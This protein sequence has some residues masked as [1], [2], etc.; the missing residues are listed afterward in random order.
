VKHR[1]RKGLLYLG[2]GF[3]VLFCLRLA[4]GYVYPSGGSGL[5]VE[6]MTNALVTTLGG[7]DEGLSKANYA[8]EKFKVERGDSGQAYTVSQKY[9]KIASVISRTS[10]FEE[11]EERVRDL[12]ARHSALIQFERAAGLPGA[13]RVD[14]AIGVPPARFDPM[15]GELKQIGE[16]SSLRVDKTDKTNEYRELKAKRATLEK[17]RDA[18]V[19]LKSK[20]GRIEEFTSLEN[21]ILEIEDEIQS[22]GVSLG[23]YD[24]ENEFC[25]VR[26]SLLEKG[27]ATATISFLHRVRVALAWTIK[28]YAL[29]VGI[30]FF[31]A[32]FSLV[33][34]VLLQRL[35][36][37]PPAAPEPAASA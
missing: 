23:D 14:L 21:R 35:R 27:A 15:V 8:S 24:E 10:A 34:V 20:G 13:R 33:V 19:A 37:I 28:Y 16:L 12:T 6:S 17:T 30:L 22:A 1:I 26:L 36:L 25:T 18:L 2:A 5:G 3:I 11:D 9:E 32:L 4:Y 7:R 29:L 31:G